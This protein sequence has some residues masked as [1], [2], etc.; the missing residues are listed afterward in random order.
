MDICIPVGVHLSQKLFHGLLTLTL[1]TTH[2]STT[3]SAHCVSLITED[4]AW[5]LGLCLQDTDSTL[6]ISMSATDLQNVVVESHIHYV[7]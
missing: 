1:V 2:T 5:G 4:N 7:Q 3:L 6:S